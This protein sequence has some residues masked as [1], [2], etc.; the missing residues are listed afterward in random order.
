MESRTK[1]TPIAAI[2]SVFVIG[3]AVAGCA[4]GIVQARPT[5]KPEDARQ[6]IVDLV[7]AAAEQLGGEWVVDDGPRLD[8]CV[9]ERG[10]GEGVD[11]TYI[12]RRT[13]RGQAQRDINTL[14]RLWSDRGLDTERFSSAGG[15]WIGLNGRGAGASNIGYS[16]SDLG[17]GD[18]VS[19]ASWCAAGDF[20]EMRERGEE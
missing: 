17:G 12:K 1:T 16:S 10:E 5:Q 18:S 11:Y 19:G 15:A 8:T 9:N 6:G 2:A 20:V 4:G 3:A 7:D 13:D 14:E